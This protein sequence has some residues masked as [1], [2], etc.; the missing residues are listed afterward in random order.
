VIAAARQGSTSRLRSALIVAAAALVGSMLALGAAPEA[1]EAASCKKVRVGGFKVKKVRV[2]DPVSCHDGRS[3]AKRWVKSD[4]DD[5]NPISR[6]GN[7]WFCSW[8]RR[9]PQSTTT[10][11]AE[12]DA[13]PG[14][15]VKFAVRHR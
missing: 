1:S 8:R 10:G 6:G 7:I 12:C 13:D 15:E 14:E 3:V 5:L 2:S 11:T 9:A 4:Y